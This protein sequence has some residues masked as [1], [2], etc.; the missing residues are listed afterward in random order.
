MQDEKS[1]HKNFAKALRIMKAR[2]YEKKQQEEHKKRADDRKT[3]VGSGDRSQRIRTYNW[4]QNRVTD[5][6]IGFQANLDS[7]IAGNLQ[8]ITQALLDHDRDQLRGAMGDL[9]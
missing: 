2:L 3:Q 7:V 6:R 9:D 4:P 5:H 1:Q 8:P